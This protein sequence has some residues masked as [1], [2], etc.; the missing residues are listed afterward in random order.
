MSLRRYAE[1]FSAMSRKEQKEKENERK[2]LTKPNFSMI[3]EL[4]P[5]WERL[6]VKKIKAE[7]KR[8]L[9][10]AIAKVRRRKERPRLESTT[11]FSK[12]LST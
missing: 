12:V 6:R 2:A 9:V 10:S 8:N 3:Q 7:E 11:R 1:D 4:I 5:M